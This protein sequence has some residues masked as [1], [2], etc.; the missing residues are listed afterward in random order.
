MP[1]LT[2]PK[3]KPTKQ[4]NRELEE[5]EIVRLMGEC[6]DPPPVKVPIFRFN[7]SISFL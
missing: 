6:K 4:K 3:P 7:I 5:D 1:R 2:F